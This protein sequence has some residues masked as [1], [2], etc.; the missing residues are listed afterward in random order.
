MNKP[1]PGRAYLSC[2]CAETR[3]PDQHEKSGTKSLGKRLLQTAINFCTNYRDDQG[4]LI[5]D[6]HLLAAGVKSKS[7]DEA[8]KTK[9]LNINRTKYLSFGFEDHENACEPK[10][11]EALF[12]EAKDGSVSLRMS[13][14]IHCDGKS[15]I[16]REAIKTRQ[17]GQVDRTWSSVKTKY[18]ENKKNPVTLWTRYAENPRVK[19][20]RLYRKGGTFRAH[21]KVEPHHGLYEGDIITIKQSKTDGNDPPSLEYDGD[22]FN[23][24]NVVIKDVKEDSFEYDLFTPTDGEGVIPAED[25]DATDDEELFDKKKDSKDAKVPGIIESS[26]FKWVTGTHKPTGQHQN[27]GKDTFIEAYAWYP[28]KRQQSTDYNKRSGR[29]GK[30]EKSEEKRKEE[31]GAKEKAPTTKK[32]TKSPEEKKEEQGKGVKRKA[33]GSSEKKTPKK[34]RR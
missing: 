31:K 17:F 25:G 21:A 5:K 14:K 4:R 22:G 1:S 29:S 7:G 11:D 8:H 15:E 32:T 3:T 19:I 9:M 33:I 24:E 23:R 10:S 20:T 30:K 2:L 27:G 12:I 28:E 26:I 18:I 16:E 6:L 34:A 13:K